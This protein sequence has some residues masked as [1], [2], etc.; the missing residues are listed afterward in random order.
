MPAGNA[1]FF[2]LDKC[3]AESRAKEIIIRRSRVVIPVSAVL[4]G[5]LVSLRYGFVRMKTEDTEEFLHR[6][7]FSDCTHFH[8]RIPG[9]MMNSRI[10][11]VE[12]G[13]MPGSRGLVSAIDR[14][15][16]L[17]GPDGR[18]H[19]RQPDSARGK[20][21]LSLETLCIILF[22]TCHFFRI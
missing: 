14:P 19:E 22:P 4:R 12:L 9:G 6:I 7:S 21:A 11:S 20:A 17:D 13:K 15:D 8:C 10:R 18:Q 3:P 16:S 1:V 2:G 5:K